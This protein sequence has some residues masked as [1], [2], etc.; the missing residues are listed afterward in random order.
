[1]FDQHPRFEFIAHD[2][3]WH[4]RDPF[5]LSKMVA[6]PEDAF[7]HEAARQSQNTFCA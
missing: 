6:S 5:S 4:Q 1:M 3:R 2:N 7:Q